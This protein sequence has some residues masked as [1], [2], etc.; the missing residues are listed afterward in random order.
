MRKSIFLWVLIP[1]L[2]VSLNAQTNQLKLVGKPELLENEIVARRDVNGR[3]CAGITIISDKDGFRYDSNMGVVGVD[4]LPGKDIIYLMP[5]EQVLEIYLTGF[6]P[7]KLI[8]YDIGIKLKPKQMWRI[9]LEAKETTKLDSVPVAIYSTPGYDEIIIDGQKY[10][11][12]PIYSLIPGI[13]TIKIAQSGYKTLLDTIEVKKGQLKFEYNLEEE[14]LA[15][16]KIIS[17]PAGADVYLDDIYLGKTPVE[18]FFPVGQYVLRLEKSGYQRIEETFRVKKPRAAKQFAMEKLVAYLQVNTY[19]YARI[20]VDGKPIPANQK[21]SFSPSM[22]FVKIYLAGADSLLRNEV[23]KLGQVKKI[24]YY[25]DFPNGEARIAAEPLNAEIYLYDRNNVPV[26]SGKTSLIVKRL[27]TG[28]Y[29]LKITADGYRDH[30]ETIVLTPGQIIERSV[31]LEPETIAQKSQP[32]KKTHP[33]ESSDSKAWQATIFLNPVL[34]EPGTYLH[35]WTWNPASNQHGFILGGGGVFEDYDASYGI[36]LDKPY[37]EYS[38]RN[39]FYYTV[40]RIGGKKFGFALN[41]GKRILESEEKKDVNPELTSLRSYKQISE[42]ISPVISYRFSFGLSLALRGNFHN[43]KYISILQN[44]YRD[45]N[46]IT[47]IDAGIQQNFNDVLFLGV[48]ANEIKLYVDGDEIKSDD[49]PRIIE[50]SADLKMGKLWIGGGWRLNRNPFLKDSTVYFKATLN[51]T[52]ALWVTGLYSKSNNYFVTDL[53]TNL[54]APVTILSAGLRWDMDGLILG[55]DVIK[56]NFSD[57]NS[58]PLV[59]GE[60]RSFIDR[61]HVRHVVSV[62]LSL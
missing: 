37:T 1:V 17:E 20:T 33:N 25:P 47:T 5:D 23:L 15:P 12:G 36:S 42:I 31:N 48:Y 7:L 9:R 39:R 4:D 53:R 44:E 13:H 58:I 61:S 2:S 29:Y 56:M 19:D 59:V 41:Y 34:I 38:V 60:E 10:G 32:Y 57:A 24:D 30:N 27:P 43:N 22:V 55:Y 3:Y 28:P 46:R 54:P 50:A 6:E 49:R 18:K 52:K 26:G 62:N 35:Q 16:I 14:E 8:L 40:L 21:V 51:L 11:K 45:S